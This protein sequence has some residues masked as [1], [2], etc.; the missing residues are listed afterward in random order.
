M[1]PKSQRQLQLGETIK[2]TMSDI[3]LRE[4]ILTLP[5]SYVTILEADVSPDAKNVKIYIDI[6]G[7]EEKHK[8]ITKQLN[9]AA[10]ALK[11][12]MSKK[13][14]SRSVPQIRF[15]LDALT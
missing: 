11:T 8:E 1:K 10:P 5:G 9:E 13:M 14:F 2:R 6:F 7:N 15:I 12:L 4:D 3:F